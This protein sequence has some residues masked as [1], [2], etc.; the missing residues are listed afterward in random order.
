MQSQLARK[1]HEVLAKGA[2]TGVD[3]LSQLE[4]SHFVLWAPSDQQVLQRCIGTFQKFAVQATDLVRITLVLPFTSPPSADSF[5]DITDLYHHPLL[6]D[7]WSQVICDRTI[8]RQPGSYTFTGQYGPVTS[9]KSF[10]SCKSFL[11]VTL[12]TRSVPAI[13]QQVLHWKSSLASYAVGHAIVI[14]LR[15]HDLLQVQQTLTKFKPRLPICWERPSSSLASCREFP[16]STIR[17]FL[18]QTGI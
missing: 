6:G 14:D 11:C 8:L 17:G 9:C 2:P 12:S 18:P 10:P 7:K 1:F 16:R 3:F 13:S 4:G 5:E 15:T